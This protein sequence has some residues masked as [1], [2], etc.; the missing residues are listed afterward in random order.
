MDIYMVYGLGLGLHIC[1]SVCLS[2]CMERG[3]ER[4]RER[5]RHS[6]EFVFSQERVR[7]PGAWGVDRDTCLAEA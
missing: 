6:L 4:E 1:M 3:G 2:V 5:E 7:G